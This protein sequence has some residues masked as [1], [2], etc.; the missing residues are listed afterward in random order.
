MTDVV[1]SYDD[2]EELELWAGEGQ[3]VGSRSA[4]KSYEDGILR[5]LAWLD[6]RRDT[7]PHK[8]EEAE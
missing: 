8:E 7:G 6:G 4:G 2:I 3:L 5:T 1:R